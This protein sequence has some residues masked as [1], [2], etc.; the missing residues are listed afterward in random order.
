M[1][2]IVPFLFLCILVWV[3]LLLIAGGTLTLSGDKPIP[4]ENKKPTVKPEAKKP[5]VIGGWMTSQVTNKKSTKPYL[6]IMGQLHELK[7]N[8]VN[9][10]KKDGYKIVY[11]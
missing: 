4:A 11:K 8:E 9:K 6:E 10:L 3:A 7:P 1:Y 5:Y 2:F